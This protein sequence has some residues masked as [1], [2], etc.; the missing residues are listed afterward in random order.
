MSREVETGQY[1]E[2][3]RT[4][5]EAARTVGE[6]VRTGKEVVRSNME[7]MAAATYESNWISKKI[8]EVIRSKSTFNPKT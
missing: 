8:Q 4:E 5:V 3:F 2:A 7:A 6:A 1:V